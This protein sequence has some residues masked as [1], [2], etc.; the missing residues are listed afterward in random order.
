MSAASAA[1]RTRLALEM[2]VMA[3]HLFEYALAEASIDRAF[4]R[5][6]EC[7][8]GVLRV[9]EDLHD[10]NSYSQTFVVSIGK[11]AHTLVNAL[12][13]QAGS[14]FQGIVATSV[15]PASQI[16]GFR[17]FRG[18]HPTP[19]EESIRAA[20]AMLKSLDGMDASALVIFLLSGGGSS[21]AEKPID[22]EISLED[23]IATYRALVHSGAPIAEIN[24]IRKHL[25]AIKGGRLAAAAAPAQQVSLLVSDVPDNTSDALASG[26]T[27]PDSTSV[28]DCYAI[29]AKYG[30]LEQFPASVGELFQRR[31][32][33]E[34]PKKDNL[35]FHRSRWWPILSNASL[36]EACQAEAQR[37]R[38][39]VAVDNSCDDWDY[40]RARDY[41]LDRLRELRKKS[42]RVCLISGGEVTVKVTNGGTGGRNQQFALACAA[43]IS[44]EN[45]TALSAGTDGID[46]NSTAAGAVVDGTTMER[47]KTR[48]LD[49]QAH[50]AAFNAFPFF[51]SLGDAVVTG[52]TGNNLRDLRIL[53]AY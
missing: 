28:E 52:P 32:L 19:N 13:M 7:E 5:H 39:A 23:L 34:T 29:A 9:C 36:V 25:S 20:Q 42:E 24:A 15:E 33:E 4:Q 3:R 18:G 40:L 11:A 31:A 37:Q 50:L 47:A 2:R 21:I 1:D 30:M 51:E 49:P 44:G 22:D 53:L 45:I 6:V 27:M 35:V 16:K 46:G 41:L 14:R 17:Y 8:R 26:P 12:E 43:K 38:F 48:G 10:L